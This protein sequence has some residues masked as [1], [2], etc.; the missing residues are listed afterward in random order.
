VFVIPFV[1]KFDP[2][3]KLD[4]TIEE[5]EWPASLCILDV[6]SS[7]T[8]QREDKLFAREG[9]AA[10]T[11]ADMLLDRWYCDHNHAVCWKGSL[12]VNFSSLFVAR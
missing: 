7:R 10:G 1:I 9:E 6:F 8:K 3:I 2:D 4:P 11:T 12:Y 5:L